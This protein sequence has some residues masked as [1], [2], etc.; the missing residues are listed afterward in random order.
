M[1]ELGEGQS[2]SHLPQLQGSLKNE[3]FNLLAVLRMFSRLR[4]GWKDVMRQMNCQSAVLKTLNNKMANEPTAV[5]TALL[6]STFLFSKTSAASSLARAEFYTRR[7][8]VILGVWA[9]LCQ[10]TQLTI[11]SFVLDLISHFHTCSWHRQWQIHYSSSSSSKLRWIIS[12]ERAFKC[13]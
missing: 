13:C 7:F 2:S 3:F 8:D 9:G 1:A 10:E 4:G 6:H 5:S 12:Q 11:Q